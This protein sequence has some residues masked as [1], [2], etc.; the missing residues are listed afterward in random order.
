MPSEVSKRVGFSMRLAMEKELK[1]AEAEFWPLLKLAASGNASLKD[2]RLV[3]WEGHKAALGKLWPKVGKDLVRNLCAEIDARVPAN[4]LAID[5]DEVGVLV[6][7]G[8]DGDPFWSKPETEIA[9]ALSAKLDVKDDAGALIETWVP[10]A[11]EENGF[12]F[13]RL[14]AMAGKS[15]GASPSGRTVLG[16]AVFRYCPIMDIGQKEI[17]CCLCEAVWPVDEKIVLTEAVL[18]GELA[19]PRRLLALDLDTLRNAIQQTKQGFP[20]LDED[21]ATL[22]PVHYEILTDKKASDQIV[23]RV[24]EM[25]GDAKDRILFEIVKIPPEPDK[26]ILTAIAKRLQSHSGGVLLRVAPGFDAFP[27]VPEGEYVS[28]G[29]SLRYDMRPEDAIIDALRAF[30]ERARAQGHRC[31]VH[32]LG[33]E[34]AAMAAANA[35]FGLVGSDALHPPLD[36]S[37]P[38]LDTL[39]PNDILW[40][41]EKKD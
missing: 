33:S 29:V 2:M 1:G 41:I 24:E 18:S 25:A 30:A 39:Q 19:T 12:L 15:A 26:K 10:V 11:I 4:G 31:H 17:Y 8:V 3:R 36:G 16:N 6:V 5:Y 9:K 20:G 38:E 27:V 7:G 34:A 13:E 32:G 23:R 28:V 21:V 22:A 37:T 14:G 35:G 40:R